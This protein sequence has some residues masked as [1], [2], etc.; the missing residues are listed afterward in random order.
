MA[1]RTMARLLVGEH[2]L[3]SNTGRMLGKG[4]TYGSRLCNLCDEYSPEDVTHLLF[5]CPSVASFRSELWHDVGE[6]AP[7]GLVKEMRGMSAPE[8]TMFLF[9]G[10]RVTYTVEWGNL[11]SVVCRYVHKVYRWRSDAGSL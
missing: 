3:A 7:D 5:V 11:Y 9:S 10:F 2:C 6:C 8:L 4:C 1:C